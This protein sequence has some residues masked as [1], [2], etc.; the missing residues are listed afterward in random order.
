M[1]TK[2]WQAFRFYL[3]ICYICVCFPQDDTTYPYYLY[4]RF[5]WDFLRNNPLWLKS[6][7]CYTKQGNSW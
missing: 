4:L 2:N 7:G 5:H 1:K 6:T 3:P